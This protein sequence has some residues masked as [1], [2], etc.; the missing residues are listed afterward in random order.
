MESLKI[1]SFGTSKIQ[2]SRRVALDPNLMTTL[3]MQEGDMVR[4]DLDVQ[5]ATILI[6]REACN[7]N[8]TTAKSRRRRHV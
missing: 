4:V 3:G 8:A 6:R 1:V 5:S 7:Q 2:K